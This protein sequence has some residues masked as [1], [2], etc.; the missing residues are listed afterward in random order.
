MWY[1]VSR[2]DYDEGVIL[3][4]VNWARDGFESVKAEAWYVN[5][6]AEL[7]RYHASW[8][9]PVLKYGQLHE[10]FRR[11]GKKKLLP[12]AYSHGCGSNRQ[13]QSSI[14]RELASQGCAV[15]SID[16][17]DHSCTYI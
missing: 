1:P 15:F 16:H 17:T 12:I 4:E 14:F 11:G 8:T 10:D 6:P 5:L 7:L 13:H 9:I 2:Q 3:S